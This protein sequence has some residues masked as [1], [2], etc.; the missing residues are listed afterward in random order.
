MKIK[1]LLFPLVLK[2]LITK[3][4]RFYSIFIFFKLL[5]AILR[6][7]LRTQRRALS[8]TVWFSHHTAH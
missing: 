5:L 1:W 4:V 2:T 3:T 6:P 7:I 8:C